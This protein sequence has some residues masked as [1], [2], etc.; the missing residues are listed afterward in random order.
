MNTKSQELRSTLFELIQELRDNPKENIRNPDKDFLRNRKLPFDKIIFSL[1]GMEGNTLSNELLNQWGCSIDTATSAAFV[2]QRAKILTTAFEKLFH[3]FVNKT[4]T[5]YLFKGYRLLA[6]DGS[7]IH[8]PTNKNDL[9]SL[10][11]FKDSRKPYNL[12]HLNALYDLNQH[13]YEDVIVL[14]RKL[15]NECKALTDMVD[16]S[17]I[18]TPAIILADRGYESYNN[19]AHIQQ[20]GWK[21]LIRIKDFHGHAS[22][23][24]HGFELPSADEFDVDIDLNLTRKQT[25]KVKELLKDK[26]HYRLIGKNKTFD[27][28]PETNRKSDPTV[29]YKLPFRIVRFKIT[30]DTYEVVVTNL[31]RTKFSP[32]TLKELYF[33]RWGIETSFR[34]L[35]YTIGLLHFHSK[36]VEYILQ[37]I[38]A[39]LIMYNFSEIITQHVIIKKRNRKYDYKVNFSVAAH[40]CRQFFLGKVTPP[41]IEALIARH[42]T[43]IRPGR[44]RPRNMSEKTSVS[45]MYRVA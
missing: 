17:T 9:D 28:L 24:L 25:N 18:K 40:I 19:M 41:N 2:Q 12:L 6:V 45:F 29:M 8:I 21:F 16:R 42:I 33:K 30:D 20:K 13:T 34:D 10:Y 38:Y 5:D 1:L 14:R 3:N 11:E 4:T 31:D 32:Q 26:N 22:G 23:I 44:S 36:K 35:K 43:P 15:S 39:R 37:E 27:Y 7:D